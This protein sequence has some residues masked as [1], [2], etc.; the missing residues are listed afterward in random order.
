MY[1][2]S[3]R[4]VATATRSSADPAE[5]REHHGRTE[6]QVR[7]RGEGRGEG[8]GAAPLRYSVCPAGRQRRLLCGRTSRSSVSRSLTLS[9]ACLPACLPASLLPPSAY[10]PVCAGF[11]RLVVS[12]YVCCAVSAVLR[13]QLSMLGGRLFLQHRDQD[14]VRQWRGWLG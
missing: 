10:L 9:S 3:Y 12:V 11:A 1:V 4:S 5:C 14:Q 6:D 13:V 8:V 2:C 7:G